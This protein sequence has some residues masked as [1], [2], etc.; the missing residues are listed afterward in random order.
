LGSGR[1]AA[2]ADLDIALAV[3]VQLAEAEAAVERVRA[4]VDDQ[5]VEQDRFTVGGGLL[6]GMAEDLGADAV[7][8]DGRGGS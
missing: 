4:V 3:P 2:H 7:A 8:L 1:V 5:D 6:D